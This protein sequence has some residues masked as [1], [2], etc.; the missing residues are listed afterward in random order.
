MKTNFGKLIGAS[1]CAAVVGLAVQANA[2]SYD[3]YSTDGSLRDGNRNSDF[4][5]AHPTVGDTAAFNL[6]SAKD[7]YTTTFGGDDKAGFS[8]TIAFGDNAQPVLTSAFLKAGSY[9]LYWGSSDLTAFNAGTFDSITLWNKNPNGIMNPGHT[10]Y[11]GTSHA[12]LLGKEGTSVP[13]AGST[14][15]LLGAGLA[16]VGLLRRRIGC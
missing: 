5:E 14:L 16:G 2:I 10:S 8:V 4:F 13:D 1:V 9:Y 15:M 7:L 6:G 3:L 12:G 11:L